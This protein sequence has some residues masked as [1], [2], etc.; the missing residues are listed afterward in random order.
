M[1]RIRKND[2][3]MVIAG[4][5]RGKVGKGI[6]VFWDRDMALVEK[7]QMVKR[8]RKPTQQNRQG[9][10]IE[11]EA[12]IHLSN[13]MLLDPKDKKRTRVGFRVEQD[14]SKVRIARRSEAVVK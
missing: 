2:E 5:S 7:A 10:I 13:L 8:H 6:Q 3:V 14:G 4:R 1:K 11:Q 9:G 12:P